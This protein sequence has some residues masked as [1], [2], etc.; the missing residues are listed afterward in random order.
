MKFCFGAFVGHCSFRLA[1]AAICGG[2]GATGGAYAVGQGSKGVII[3]GAAARWGFGIHSLRLE[4][5]HEIHLR[6]TRRFQHNNASASIM[7]LGWLFIYPANAEMLS[8]TVESQ[9]SIAEKLDAVPQAV[10]AR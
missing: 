6:Y 4:C 10:G 8:R 3:G 7:A 1:S 9:L 2:A 5:S